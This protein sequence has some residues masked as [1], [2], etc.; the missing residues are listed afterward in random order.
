M[1]TA[2]S[3]GAASLTI[4]S[5]LQ[6]WVNTS[7]TA[8]GA[9]NGNNTFTGN[10]SG[11][12]FNSW[13]NF[14]L[15]VFDG[16]VTSAILDIPLLRFP[17]EDPG[18]HTVGIYDVNTPLLA[19]IFSS[20]G[21]AGYVDLGSGSLYGTVTGANEQHFVTLSAQ[22]LADINAA[23]P[24]SFILG[25]TN[26]TMNAED[27]AFDVDIGIYTNANS[28]NRPSLILETS[29]VPEPASL[30]LLGTG[31]VGVGVRRWRKRQANASG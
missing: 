15:P 22:A 27:P 4:D 8:N 14:I 26:M 16:T 3:V 17:F 1:V 6:G 30:L 25:F 9:D 24:G 2:S 21:V 28:I 12:R 18:L 29:E 5:D 13:A 19:F 31:L 23:G 10:E 7:G 11:D 20:S